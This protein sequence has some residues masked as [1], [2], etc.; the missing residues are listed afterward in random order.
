MLTLF[1]KLGHVWE[2]RVQLCMSNE[3]NYFYGMAGQGHFIT[4]YFI[5]ISYYLLVL[6]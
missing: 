3:S 4:V 6:I 1:D 2:K 5:V